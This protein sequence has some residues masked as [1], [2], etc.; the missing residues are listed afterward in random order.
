MTKIIFAEIGWQH[1]LYWQAENRKTLQKINKLIK[2]IERDGPLGGE[3]KPEQLK[4]GK[5][6]KY[7][8]RI[9]DKNRLVYRVEDGKITI[10]TCVGHYED[11]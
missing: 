4:H 7:S 9:D 8:R 6:E 1:Y 5:T 10:E 11:K 3:G 2:S